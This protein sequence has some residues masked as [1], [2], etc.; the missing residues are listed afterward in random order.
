MLD[1][2][3]VKFSLERSAMIQDMETGREIYVDPAAASAEYQKRFET[4][5]QQ[6]IDICHRR[7]AR[8]MTLAIDQPLDMA[9]LE[10]ISNTRTLSARDSRERGPGAMSRKARS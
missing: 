1:P 3:E 9:L 10:L 6:L 2:T 4:H 7:G 8:M 5:E